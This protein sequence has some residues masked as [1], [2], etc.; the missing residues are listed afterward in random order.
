[1]RMYATHNA[2][3]MKKFVQ[4]YPEFQAKSNSVSKHVSMVSVLSKYIKSHSECSFA[5]SINKRTDLTNA[6]TLST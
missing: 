2:E 3:D 6:S 1:M 4:S 5:S